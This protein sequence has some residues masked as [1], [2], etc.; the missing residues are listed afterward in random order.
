[1]SLALVARTLPAGGLPEP[2]LPPGYRPA[3]GSVE[4]GLWDEADQVEAALQ[5]SP[6]LVRDPAVTGYVQDVACRVAGAYC[7]DIRVYVVENPAFNASMSPNGALVV[8]TGVLT[9]IRDDDELAVLIGHELAHYQQAHARGQAGALNGFA[10]V[11][12][13]MSAIPYVGIG[14]AVVG[15]VAFSGYSRAQEQESDLAG[16]ELARRAGYSP[17][18]AVTLWEGLASEVAVVRNDDASLAFLGTHR[19]ADDRLAVLRDWRDRGAAPAVERAPDGVLLGVLSANYARLLGDQIDANR[20][21]Q[22]SL[23][24]DRHAGMGLPPEFVA[25][26][27]GENL[28]LRGRPDDLVAARDQYALATAGA[29]PVPQAYRE[30]GY[31][32]HA[33]GERAAASASLRRY[34]ELV[35]AAPDAGLV[36]SLLVPE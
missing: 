14:V 4:R 3:P 29:S 15:A 35:P 16:A 27:R 18:A 32:Q 11:S 34:L 31:L 10:A 36:R 30:L 22:T 13:A 2:V 26:F 17:D 1:L 8:W 21:V 28:R 23:L 9:R 5:R 7:G 33:A 24:L 19:K 20:F 6:V 12:T 25:F